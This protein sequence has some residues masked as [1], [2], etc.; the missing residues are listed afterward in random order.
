MKRLIKQDDP[1]YQMLTEVA[2]AVAD[3]EFTRAA[4]GG[5]R[6]PV[7]TLGYQELIDIAAGAMLAWEQLRPQ[8]LD[9]EPQAEPVNE[10]AEGL[11]R[12]FV[13]GEQTGNDIGSEA[14]DDVYALAREEIGD[15]RCEEIEGEV[16]AGL[17]TLV[18]DTDGS[19]DEL[20]KLIGITPEEDA[21]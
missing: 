13:T 17:K 2:Q 1:R 6:V 10:V 3:K 14:L 9:D 16:A 8:S 12:V 5:L 18:D 15:E 11:V 21:P 7:V 20:N 19:L 4:K